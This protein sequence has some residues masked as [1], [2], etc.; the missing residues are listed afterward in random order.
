M[1]SIYISHQAIAAAVNLPYRPMAWSDWRQKIL[2]GIANVILKDPTLGVEVTYDGSMIDVTC[3]SLLNMGPA[4][5][6]W[7]PRSPHQV[8]YQVEHIIGLPVR[9]VNVHVRGLR[10]SNPDFV[11]SKQRS[12]MG[13]SSESN[14]N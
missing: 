6:R 8:H 4:S 9:Q 5:N 10:I 12:Q 11:P 1:G 3:T 13:F 7:R 2:S 14:T